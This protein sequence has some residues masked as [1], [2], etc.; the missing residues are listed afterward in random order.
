[1]K[2]LRV[3]QDKIFGVCEFCEFHHK[4]KHYRN[5]KGDVKTA[6]KTQPV[7]PNG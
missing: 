2:N 4:L 1:M 3:R 5:D 7:W 6:K